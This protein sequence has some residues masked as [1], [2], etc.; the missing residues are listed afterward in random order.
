MTLASTKAIQFKWTILYSSPILFYNLLQLNR[1]ITCKQ[2]TFPWVIETCIGGEPWQPRGTCT[3]A[4][5]DNI[6]VVQWTDTKNVYA[7]ISSSDSDE[8]V[9]VNCRVNSTKSDV[10]CPLIISN[11]NSFLRTKHICN[12][13][14][15]RETMK[16]CCRVFWRV[17]NHRI[18]NAYVISKANNSTFSNFNFGNMKQ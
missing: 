8:L 9:T 18:T 17:L 14:I 11:Y 12:Y 15:G 10:P 13:F 2:K 5:H 3:F 1:N 7:I 4:Y 6:T 16:W